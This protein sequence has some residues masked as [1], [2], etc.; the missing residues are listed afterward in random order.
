MTTGAADKPSG[1]IRVRQHDFPA[2]RTWRAKA[3]TCQRYGGDTPWQNGKVRGR[4]GIV[5]HACRHDSVMRLWREPR[6]SILGCSKGLGT[7]SDATFGS[8]RHAVH[9]MPLF[10]LMSRRSE[11]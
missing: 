8:W 10:D 1:Q 11:R 4:A 9:S 2:S 3:T 5:E 7:A 6:G